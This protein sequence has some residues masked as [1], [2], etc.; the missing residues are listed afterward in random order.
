MFD[1]DPQQPNPQQDPSPTVHADQGSAVAQGEGAVAVG[2]HAVAVGG[3]VRD[4]VVATGDGNVVVTGPQE[5]D[6]VQIG[7]PIQAERI[8]AQNVVSGVQIVH[9]PETGKH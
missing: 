4:S 1:L 6:Q 5:G 8:Q 2:D 9:P 7:G 3:D